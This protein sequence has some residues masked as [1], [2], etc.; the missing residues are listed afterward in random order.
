MQADPAPARP[1]TGLT[2]QDA[3]PDGLGRLGADP[4]QSV[5]IGS[6]TGT[7]GARLDAEQVVEQ[8]G[9]QPR[10][11]WISLFVQYVERDNTEAAARV[12]R[13]QDIDPRIGLP[14]GE[15]PFQRGVLAGGDGV[16]SD[17]GLQPQR[18]GRAHELQQT[19]RAR[20]FARFDI[21]NEIMTVCPDIAHRPAGA[22]GRGQVALIE[23]G[24]EHQ[25][26]ATARAA[27]E[28]VRREIQ[29]VDA[30]RRVAGRVH[31]DGQIGCA[32]GAIQAQNGCMAVQQMRQ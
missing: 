17:L 8:H 16:V 19:R 3:F 27:H 15:G 9:H 7:S 29:R 5:A 1:G 24:T 14:G 11:D 18:Q 12:G 23:V 2:G 6:G 31:V 4:Q 21:L 20:P 28:F 13:A 32:C 26:T 25:H 22:L 10:R 30:R